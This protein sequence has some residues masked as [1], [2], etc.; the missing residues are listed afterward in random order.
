MYALSSCFVLHLYTMYSLTLKVSCYSSKYIKV[1]SACFVRH[2]NGLS[3]RDWEPYIRSIRLSY[4]KIL[5]PSHV[6]DP[7]WFY[8]FPFILG[9]SC[10]CSGFL[11]A[12]TSSEPWVRWIVAA[13]RPLICCLQGSWISTSGWMALRTR[14]SC[15]STIQ[16][17]QQWLRMIV[18]MCLRALF[19][20]S[21]FCLR[22]ISRPPHFSP[23]WVYR[24]SIHVNIHMYIWS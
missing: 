2:M 20:M 14:L 19:C 11:G 8:P 6:I 21:V 9:V 15:F 3:F 17:T 5:K 18:F 23:V 24:L 7:N 13:V 12:W 10:S 1:S 22:K 4:S 16:Q